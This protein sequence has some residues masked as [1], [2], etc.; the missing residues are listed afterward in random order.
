VGIALL[1]QKLMMSLEILS[2]MVIYGNPGEAKVQL[3]LERVLNLMVISSA[4]F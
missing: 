2:R 4:A 1:A 3:S